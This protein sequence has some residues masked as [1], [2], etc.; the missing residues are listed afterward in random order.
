MNIGITEGQ[1]GK[2]A[3]TEVETNAAP[4]SETG[5]EKIYPVGG[6]SL[7]EIKRILTSVGHLERLTTEEAN[8][9]YPTS[10]PGGYPTRLNLTGAVI[11][12]EGDDDRSHPSVVTELMSW[13]RKVSSAARHQI[14]EEDYTLSILPT[15]LKRVGY[16]GG[17]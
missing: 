12:P 11:V 7:E 16:Q 13:Y 6:E 5:A 9:Q 8:A 1:E 14:A 17:G 3:S 10:W 2:M 4:E 15:G